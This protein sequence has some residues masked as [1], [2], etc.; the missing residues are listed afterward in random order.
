M[1][2]INRTT[3]INAIYFFIY[4]YL[5]NYYSARAVGFEPTVAHR[6]NGFQDRHHKPLGHTPNNLDTC[7]ASGTRTRIDSFAENCIIHYTIA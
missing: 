7:F 1:V 6:H 5:L 2:A 3:N 4:N